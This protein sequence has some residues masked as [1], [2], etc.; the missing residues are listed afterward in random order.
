MC[1]GFV[2]DN[3]PV[4]IGYELLS[5]PK[6]AGLRN[7]RNTTNRIGTPTN[8]KIRLMSSFFIIGFIKLLLDSIWQQCR[9]YLL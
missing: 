9:F 7:L 5:I 6:L 4:E 2:L 8:I 3:L 1:G